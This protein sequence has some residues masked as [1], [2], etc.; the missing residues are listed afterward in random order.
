MPTYRY[1]AD[2]GTELCIP[3]TIAEMQ[4]REDKNGDIDVE[5]L[6][7]HRDYTLSH[8][9]A[10]FKPVHSEALGWTD[11]AQIPEAQAFE[12][13]HGMAVDYDNELCPILRSEKQRKDYARIYGYDM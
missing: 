2:D 8:R 11:P 5:G 1:K 12:H 10:I 7:F 4:Q 6:V 13:K 9:P 3:M